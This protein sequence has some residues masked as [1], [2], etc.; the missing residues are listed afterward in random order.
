MRTRV[1]LLSGLLIAGGVVLYTFISEDG[2]RGKTQL[3]QERAAL[4]GRVRS[5]KQGNDALAREAKALQ[6]SG[7]E[8]LVLEEAVRSELGYV[9]KDEV[10]ILTDEES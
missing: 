7:D 10:I 1:L 6:D 4:E 8:N 9:K 2:W 3:Q 5:L